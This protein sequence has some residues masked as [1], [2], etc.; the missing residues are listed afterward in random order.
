[1]DGEL[2]HGWT[3]DRLAALARKAARCTYSTAVELDEAQDIAA[4]ALVEILYSAE[5]APG[6]GDLMN[7]ARQAINREAAQLVRGWGIDHH[8][9]RGPAHGMIHGFARYWHAGDRGEPEW[10]ENLVERVAVWQVAARLHDTDYEVLSVLG[11]FGTYEASAL[12][13]GISLAA[14]KQR[15]SVARRAARRHWYYPEPPA[16]QWGRDARL[17]RPAI[18]DTSIVGARRRQ[19]AWQERQAS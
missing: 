15:L 8:R 2:P 6:I 12:A 18:R 1:V 4:C 19:R 14:F 5:A 10:V 11:E 13:L 9:D 16:P 17:G 3:V 7:G